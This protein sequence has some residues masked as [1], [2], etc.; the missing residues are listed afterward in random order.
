[1]NLDQNTKATF[2]QYRLLKKSLFPKPLMLSLL[3]VPLICLIAEIIGFGPLSILTFIIAGPIALWIQFVIC[4]SVIIIVSH[5]YRPKWHFA[6]RLPWF[7]YIPNQ[8]I[9]YST[10]KK[11]HLHY[12]WIGLALIAVLSPWSP[13]SLIVSLFFWHLWLLAPRFYSFLVLLKQRKDGMI[14]LT[15]QELFYYIQ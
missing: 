5:S 14:K 6:W 1:M 3:V 10:Y 11:T 13:A 15:D 12:V 8:Y 7:G 2:Y 4:R 9:S